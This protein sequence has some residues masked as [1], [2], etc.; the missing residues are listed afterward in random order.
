M[1]CYCDNPKQEEEYTYVN[2]NILVSSCFESKRNEGVGCGKH[3]CFAYTTA[4]CIPAVPSERICGI[5][6][7]YSLPEE[8]LRTLEQAFDQLV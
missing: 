1:L 2:V 3:L 6:Q 7:S 8:G 4:V 5:N